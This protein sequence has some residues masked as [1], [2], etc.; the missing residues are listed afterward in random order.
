M[1]S[2][3]WRQTFDNSIST[4][5]QIV[6]DKDK[7]LQQYAAVFSN[8]INSSLNSIKYM[9]PWIHKQYLY[10]ENFIEYKG[11]SKTKSRYV[12]GARNH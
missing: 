10:S 8:N 11:Q 4:G 3:H 6:R 7:L 9:F 5:L 2:P 12:E 1:I